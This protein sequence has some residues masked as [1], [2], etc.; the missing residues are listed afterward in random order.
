MAVRPDQRR[1][2]RTGTGPPAAI[3]I[4]MAL[5]SDPALRNALEYAATRADCARQRAR[6]LRRRI[7]LGL[8]MMLC[9]VL[10]TRGV[11]WLM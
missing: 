5:M 4:T 2:R 6:L 11:L 8:T 1:R 9:V 7:V 10:S 3:V